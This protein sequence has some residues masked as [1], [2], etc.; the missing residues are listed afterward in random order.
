MTKDTPNNH[1]DR[2]TMPAMEDEKHSQILKI[3]SGHTAHLVKVLYP[4]LAKQDWSQ[5]IEKYPHIFSKD[6]AGDLQSQFSLKALKKLLE[7]QQNHISSQQIAL[8]KILVQLPAQIS[9]RVKNEIY[10][11]N[12]PKKQGY[13]AV[14]YVTE[15][16]LQN[17]VGPLNALL[18][19]L[20]ATVDRIQ[21]GEVKDLYGPNEKPFRTIM[22][23]G[24]EGT[25]EERNPGLFET[26]FNSLQR[27]METVNELI[28]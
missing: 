21:E 12:H 6:Q 5:L 1:A 20:A 8:M 22:V 2:E 14:D 4:Y 26:M 18:P 3:D 28:K 11:K 27:N 13:D 17:T 16:E 7:V 23:E 9:L 25:I 15:E 24:E 19:E 10:F